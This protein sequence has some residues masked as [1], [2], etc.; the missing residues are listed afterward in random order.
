MESVG[1]RVLPRSPLLDVRVALRP[2]GAQHGL[3]RAVVFLVT[4]PPFGYIVGMRFFPVMKSVRLRA[5]SHAR[6]T[7]LVSLLRAWLRLSTQFRIKGGMIPR[8]NLLRALTIQLVGN[9]DQP[10]PLTTV[11][12]L[13]SKS[14]FSREA[15]SAELLM[16]ND[17]T[18][19]A[20]PNSAKPGISTKAVDPSRR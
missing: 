10:R 3:W 4:I 14:R 15:E 17:E 8:F 9:P 20:D 5:R 7:E 11:E 1:A 12:S 13:W 16:S 19:K 2:A 18:S 6:E